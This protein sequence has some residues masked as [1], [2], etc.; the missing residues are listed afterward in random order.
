MKR[1]KI[2]LAYILAVFPSISEVFILREMV[3]LSRKQNIDLYIFSLCRPKTNKMHN[4]ATGLLASTYYKLFLFSPRFLSVQF[5]SFVSHPLRYIT[6]LIYITK[7]NYNDRLVLAK[8]LFH[9]PTAIYFAYLAKKFNLNHVHAHFAYI[10]ATV[11]L[12]M[13]KFLNIEFS[14]TAH[15]WDIYVNRTM[16]YEK[17]KAARFVVTCSDYSKRYLLNLYPDIFQ[18]KVI[19][20]YHGIDLEKWKPES[21]DEKLKPAEPIRILSVGRLEEKKGFI[22][23]VKACKIFK[24]RGYTFDCS[25]VGEGPQRTYL[26]KAINSYGLE[27]EIKLKGAFSQEEL[28]PFYKQA[29]LFVLPSIIV[30]NGDRDV[31]PNVLI[32]ALAMKIPVISSNIAGIPEIIEDGVTGMLVPLKSEV[33]LAETMEKLI[34]DKQ[35]RNRLLANGL[36]LVKEKFNIKK[37]AQKLEELFLNNFPSSE[38]S[39]K[40]KKSTGEGY[41]VFKRIFDV[42]FSFMAIIMTFSL[43]ALIALAIKLD[44]E[45]PVFFSHS[46]VGRDGQLF[47]LIK[48]R[49]MFQEAD[50]YEIAPFDDKDSRITKVG[51]FLRN[52]GLDE[53]PQLYNVIKGDMSLVGPR[54]EMPM[55]VKQYNSLHKRRLTVTPG[56]T[57][58]WQIKRRKGLAIHD[59]IEHDFDYIKRISFKLDFLIILKTIV[60][61]LFGYNY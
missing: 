40:H 42:I 58:L 45:G 57:G 10:P 14:F 25:I 24:E 59:E 32:E 15:A 35:L 41:Y 46:R 28:I 55:I 37:N 60:I 27:K 9:F 3:E 31:L 36:E 16:L 21:S 30:E 13:S 23:L 49:T 50:K 39:I 20:I 38:V 56:I 11:G 54:P 51:R 17:I 47:T 34:N 4:A 33:I 26:N 12:I 44:S 1:R 18:A 5:L 19:R 48:F 61:I 8:S 43:C 52:R 29:D 7:T 2:S 6:L 22:Y 53:L